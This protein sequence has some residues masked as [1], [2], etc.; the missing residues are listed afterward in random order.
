MGKSRYSGD[1]RLS[2]FREVLLFIGPS[3]NLCRGHRPTEQESLNAAAALP[4]EDFQLLFVLDAFRQ[5]LHS[6]CFCK[7][8][9]RADDGVAIL[10]GR[11]VGNKA[12]VDLDLVEGKRAKVA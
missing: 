9:D 3:Q 10:T 7:G 1:D 12:T 5:S 11:Q 2:N 6:Q 8:C 4:T